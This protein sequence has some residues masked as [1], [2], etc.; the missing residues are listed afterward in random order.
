MVMSREQHRV[1]PAGAL[2][3]VWMSAGLVVYRLC[4]REFDCD[5]C[6]LDAALRGGNAPLAPQSDRLT[7]LP[8][9]H[10]TQF[11]EDRRYSTG[12]LWIQASPTDGAILRIG[13]DG[14][15]SDLIGD[16]AGVHCGNIPRRLNGG[17]LLFEI[18]LAQGTLPI[19]APFGCC[20]MRWN[21]GLA[22]DPRAVRADPYGKGWV[23]E[24]DPVD[25]TYP[26]GLLSA[27]DARKQ[28]EFDLRGFRRRAA[29]HLLAD[30][31]EVGSCLPDGGQI[32]TDMRQLL[33][34]DRYLQ[35]LR[36][37]TT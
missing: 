11:P 12:H 31:A 33:G 9:R 37:M 29:L 15:V 5:G 2:P 22:K 6:A 3:C 25:G 21:E 17:D 26:N 28:A 8:S 23:T 14:F 35:L 27:E 7:A 16:C 30:T 20:V 34:S 32:L 10:A 24:L 1:L 18:E 36:E 13:L 19:G 4:D